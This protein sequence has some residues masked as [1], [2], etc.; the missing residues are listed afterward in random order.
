MASS[1]LV[2]SEPRGSQEQEL[3]RAAMG[4]SK[5]AVATL[6][7]RA[8]NDEDAIKRSLEVLHQTRALATEDPIAEHL[9]VTMLRAVLDQLHV[10]QSKRT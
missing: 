7:I 2:M 9:A 3:A 1:A 5:R 10:T 4:L 6:L 8:G